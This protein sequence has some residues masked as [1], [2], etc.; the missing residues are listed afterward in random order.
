MIITASMRT[1]I[2]ALYSDW[3]YNRV[4]AGYVDVLN[5]YSKDTTSYWR[6]LLNPNVVDAFSFC[7]KNPL[8]F[9]RDERFEGFSE[10]YRQIWGVTINGY[11]RYVESNVPELD[12]AIEA[13]K[14][15]SMA[16]GKEKVMWRFDPILFT[17]SIVDEVQST[18]D[19]FDKIATKL[20]RYT[21]KVVIS[22]LDHYQKVTRNIFNAY[23]P[24]ADIQKDLVFRLVHIAKRNS[25][26]L[27]I[28]HDSDVDLSDTGAITTGCFT[29]EEIN[30]ALGTR[31]V[32]PKQANVRKGCSC[33]LNA[34]IGQYNT[35][36]HNCRYCYATFDYDKA[37]ATKS[38]HNPDSSC[39]VGW[40]NPSD[41]VTYCKQE[42]WL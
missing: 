13:F 17:S 35:C 10:M 16:V 9:I 23:R 28:C 20:G 32:R 42:S 12:D 8:P 26:H 11:T 37:C 33:V 2:P 18:V 7:T 27:Y 6:Y 41:T 3:L 24:P 5:P 4:A 21:N 36:T 30:K 29:I 40:V 19:R 25:M 15:L 31:M 38:S 14:E 34:D 1:D 39:L 22:F